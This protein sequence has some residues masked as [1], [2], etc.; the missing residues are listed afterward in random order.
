MTAEV[1]HRSLLILFAQN[2]GA[3]CSLNDLC[4]VSSDNDK[5]DSSLRDLRSRLTFGRM[6]RMTLFVLNKTRPEF[7]TQNNA[8]GLTKVNKG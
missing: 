1:V 6:L 5:R 7:S 8:K 2:D 3:G 4:S